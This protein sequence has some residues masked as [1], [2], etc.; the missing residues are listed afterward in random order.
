MSKTT[1]VELTA[2]VADRKINA[3][4][5]AADLCPVYKVF[6]REE[7][8][9]FQ[10]T[11]KIDGEYIMNLINVSREGKDIWIPAIQWNGKFYV[12]DGIK[13]LSNGESVCF[14]GELG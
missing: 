3:L 14:A 12:A 8:L 10:T 2:Y 6:V 1:N 9:Q 11:T 7:K 5:K 13:E 4:M